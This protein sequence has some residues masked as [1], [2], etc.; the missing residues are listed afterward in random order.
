M[1]DSAWRKFSYV[2]SI[3]L[4][5]FSL[6]MVTYSIGN[7]WNNSPWKIED[8]HPIAELVIF[9]VL[10]WW[11]ALLE[12]CQIS[13]VGLQGIDMEKHKD[14]YPRAYAQ[15]KVITRGPNC[16]RFLT[17]RQFL[18]LFNGFL[19]SRIGGKGDGAPEEFYIGD[20]E[21]NLGATQF[22]YGNSILLLFI[23]LAFQLVTQL[24][25]CD[26]MM[27]FLELP[28]G[29][30]WTVL[31]PCLLIEATG[32]V[33]ASYVLKDYLA[34]AAGIDTATADPKKAMPKDTL[35]YIKCTW[36]WCWV[37]FAGVFMF[38]GWALSQTGATDGPGWEN[39]PGGAAVVISILF[40]LNMACAEGMQVSALA[41]AKTN[42]SSL[43][44]T[45]P[46]AY[47]MCQ[48]FFKGHNMS[49]FMVGRQF[50]V[51]L[52]MIL[53]GK[54]TGYAGS[55]GKIDGEDWGMGDGFN[56]WGL[57]SGFLGALFVC[58]VAQLMT[59]VTASLFPAA[60]I[61]NSFL[62][63]ILHIMLAIEASGVVNA[64]WPLSWGMSTLFGLKPDPIDGG[65]TLDQQILE[66]K[67]SMG[68]PIEVDADG[69]PIGPFD[70]DA[71]DWSAAVDGRLTR[72]EAVVFANSDAAADS[73]VK[74]VTTPI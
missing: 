37:I 6:A 52:T 57:Q 38:K 4:L 44:E 60:F 43:K 61:N 26:K 33:H 71:P 55:D 54:V 11:I 22:F 50:M 19:V 69:K 58:N 32:F 46:K 74:V 40:L 17:G 35:Y 18:L 30:Y 42:I 21:W 59:Q 51:A 25:A 2:W 63:W 65:A 56:E 39:L 68:I 10:L 48:V 14:E 8:S 1:A 13:Y 29:C 16:E 36:S 9:F 12:G 70:L 53:L 28:F 47:A 15:M 3:L 45:K 49:S 73:A 27:G 62:I 20:W 7:E 64:C 72:L 34:K 5:I 67:K 23:I 66:R 41:L 24:V 31:M